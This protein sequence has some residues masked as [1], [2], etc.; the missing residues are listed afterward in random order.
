MTPHKGW[1]LMADSEHNLR[2]INAEH[3]NQ[4]TYAQGL[5]DVRPTPDRHGVPSGEVLGLGVPERSVSA[6]VAGGKR[7]GIHETP[8]F[9]CTRCRAC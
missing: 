9:S 6:V 5:P 4:E 3:R 8:R 1:L 7:L 2:Q